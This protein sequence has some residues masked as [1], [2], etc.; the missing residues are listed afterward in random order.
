[1]TILLFA[2]NAHSSLAAPINST[3]TTVTLLSGTGS[4]FP[5]P[6]TGQGFKLTFNDLAT[7]LL[8]E[9]VLCTARSGDT[10]TIV[11]G[12]EGTTAQSWL[13]NDTAGMFYTA[14]SEENNIQLDQYQEGTYDNAVATGSANALTATIPSNLDFV[15][16]GFGFTLTAAYTNSSAVT[17]NLTMGSTITG[18]LPIVKA[19]NV[20]LIPGDIPSAGYPI[21]LIYSGVYSAYVMTNPA[22]G[23]AASLSPAQLQSQ[24]YTYAVATGSSDNIAVTIPSTLTTVSDGLQLEFKAGYANGTTTPTL[25]LTLGTTNTGTYTIIKGNGLPL[26]ARD[27]PGAGFVAAVVFSTTFNA[28]ILLNP[29]TGVTVAGVVTGQI[30]QFPCATAPVGYLLC[31]GQLVSKAAFPDLWAFAQTSGN[32]VSDATWLAGQY[33]SF[34]TGNLTTTFRLPQL[35]GYFL[36]SLDNGN[37]VDPGR[38]IGT[39][40]ASQN[41]SHTHVIN[42]PGHAHGVNPPYQTNINSS[43]GGRNDGFQSQLNY[44]TQSAVT[45]IGINSSGGSEARPVNIPLLTCIKY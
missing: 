44:S 22:T 26:V 35:G 45:G 18:A 34:S 36:R 17:L 21:S 9:I 40:Q 16:S 33:G 6:T 1:M 39:V 31:N 32:I 12:Q 42:D 25:T 43:Q 29:A 14:G 38:A 24:F 30:A 15:P 10:L 5:S 41:L 8:T 37:G 20:P 2:N 13:A 23:N 4:L 27:I 11:R 7:G 19:G 28:W 3:D